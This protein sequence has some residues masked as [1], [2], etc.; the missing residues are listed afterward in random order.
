M[1]GKRKEVVL[2]ETE[3]AKLLISGLLIGIILGTIISII[4][5]NNQYTFISKTATPNVVIIG[6]QT[7]NCSSFNEIGNTTIN[8]TDCRMLAGTHFNMSLKL[9]P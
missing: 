3:I 1:V 7:I 2:K 9:K 8:F 4:I 6:N 5:Y